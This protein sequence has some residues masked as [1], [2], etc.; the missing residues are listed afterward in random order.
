VLCAVAAAAEEMEHKAQPSLLGDP[1][2][3]SFDPIGTGRVRYLDAYDSQ[4]NA[5]SQNF[6][7]HFDFFKWFTGG[8]WVEVLAVEASGEVLSGSLEVLA[9]ASGQGCEVK[10]AIGGCCDDLSGPARC[11]PAHELFVHTHSHYCAYAGLG[12]LVARAASDGQW[13]G[14]IG[15]ARLTIA[16]QITM[17]PPEVEREGVTPVRPRLGGRCSRRRASRRCVCQ[18]AS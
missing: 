1:G 17:V 12:Y 13:R 10:I 6:I 7:W 5:P 15:R 4:T 16:S 8:G 18:L 11:C 3:G 9:A 2:G 14:E